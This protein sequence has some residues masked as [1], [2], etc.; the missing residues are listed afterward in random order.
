MGRKLMP[1]GERQAIHRRLCQ[2]VEHRESVPRRVVFGGSVGY[3]DQEPTW[4]TNQERQ[5]VV[6][7]NQVGINGEA[8]NPKPFLEIQLPDGFVPVGW[9]T[10]E[11]LG[12]PDVVDQDVGPCASRIWSAIRL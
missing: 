7:G 12:A 8:E 1:L 6:G 3:L 11:L 5:E 10:F 2:I 4:A 9:S